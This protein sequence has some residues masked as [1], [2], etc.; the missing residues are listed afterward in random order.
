MRH[1]KRHK[2]LAVGG[3]LADGTIAVVHAED[4]AVGRDG[5]SVRVG[6]DSLTP[7]VNDVA[8]RIE[9]NHRAS[10]AVEHVNPV[11]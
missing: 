7:C 6:E 5:N 4:I 8:V 1:A 10:A 11:I 9:D 2:Q 3:E